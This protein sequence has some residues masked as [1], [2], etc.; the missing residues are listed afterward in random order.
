MMQQ[1]SLWRISRKL[2]C[3]GS[4]FLEKDLY[5][6]SS[7]TSVHCVSRLIIFFECA[8]LYASF[9]FKIQQKPVVRPLFAKRNVVLITKL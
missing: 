8:L 6:K 1:L 4:E 3:S 5:S 7:K 2:V 9:T